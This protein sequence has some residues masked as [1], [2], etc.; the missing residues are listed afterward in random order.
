MN[1]VQLVDLLSGYGLNIQVSV[2]T[3]Q[4]GGLLDVVAT[5]R[6]LTTPDVKVVDVGL[7][8]NHTAVVTVHLIR[9]PE[10]QSLKQSYVARGVLWTPPTSGQF[11][12]RLF[13]VNLIAGWAWMLTQWRH[14][15]TP[16]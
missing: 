8:D 10:N 11:C 1:A 6:D 16:S 9:P 7:S 12:C 5:R 2:S 15:S 3:H 13:S 4:L 14:F